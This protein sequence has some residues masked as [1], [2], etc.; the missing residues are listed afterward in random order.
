MGQASIPVDLLNPGQVFACLGLLEAADLLCGSAE[1]GFDWSDASRFQLTASGT[2]NPVSAVLEFLA[3]AEVKAAVPHGWSSDEAKS[4]NLERIDHYL[5]G[6]PDRMALPIVM[7]GPNGT[8]VCLTHWSDDSRRDNFKLYSGNRSAL[9]IATAMLKGTMDKKG[10]GLT[11]GVVQLWNEQREQLTADPFAILCAMGGSFN[12]DP[13]GAWTAIDAGYSPNEH[14]HKVMASPVVEILAAWG[15]EH[16]RPIAIA[17]RKYRY[18]VWEESLPAFL[19]RA[20]LCD[21]FATLKQRRFRFPLNLSGKNKVIC[22]AIEE[23]TS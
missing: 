1:G 21:G 5:A 23:A 19:A 9:S 11:K 8:A 3:C 6:E 15:L 2:A 22:Y 12:F 10:G 18:A 14:K 7:R 16:A 4:D 13:R 17:I 20:A